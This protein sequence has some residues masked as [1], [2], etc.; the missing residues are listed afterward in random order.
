MCTL[1]TINTA[2]GFP[3]HILIL[4][5]SHFI[6]GGPP[7]PGLLVRRPGLVGGGRFL[8]V[9]IATVVVL[10]VTV[11]VR[12]MTVILDLVGRLVAIVLVSVVALV[13][14]VVLVLVT[15]AAAVL[16]ICSLRGRR[17]DN[18]SGGGDGQHDDLA[19]EG[20]GQ[21][22]ER[23]GRTCV[24]HVE[25]CGRGEMSRSTNLPRSERGSGMIPM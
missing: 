15:L 21:S 16:N 4:P 3:C 24:D 7:V 8:R 13:R 22:E 6:C 23:G 2:L 10:F 12:P 5:H 1:T 9:R 14:V 19:G 17:E 25:D 11:V 18:Q 20:G